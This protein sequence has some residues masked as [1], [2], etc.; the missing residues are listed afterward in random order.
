ML[1]VGLIRGGSP[2]EEVLEVRLHM[3]RP[4][5]GIIVLNLVVVPRHQAR[6][7]RVKG[8]EIRVGAI[9]R[10]E[11]AIAGEVGGGGTVMLAHDPI[12]KS[13]RKRALVDVI[14]KEDHGSG[15][16]SVMCR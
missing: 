16:S 15:F 1:V 14:P 10:V 6:R 9:K 2:A 4:R 7:R 12:R 3:L 5:V 13:V 11:I 8:L